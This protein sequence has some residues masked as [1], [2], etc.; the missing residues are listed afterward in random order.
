MSPLSVCRISVLSAV[1]LMSWCI[2]GLHVDV[3]PSK[4]LFRLGQRQQLFCRVQDCP[5]KPSVSW[6]L[7]E[8]Q[9]LAASISSNHT[10]STVTFDPV[11]I[12]HE[13]PILCRVSCG[14]RTIQ[15]LSN[16]RVYS[17]P[18]APQI[19]GQDRLRMGAESFLTC[20]VSHVYPPERLTL[21]WLQG[22]TVRESIMGDPGATTLRSEYR[23]QYGDWGRT[24]SCRATLDLEDLPTE[25]RTQETEVL[26]DPLLAPVVTVF[27]TSVLLMAGAQLN[28]SCTVKGHPE[29]ELSWSFRSADGQ[30][31]ALGSSG[32]LVIDQV[33]L[34][35]DGRY[36][37]EA[38]NSE[39]K[40]IAGVEVRVHAPPTNISLSVS[41][42][43]QVLEGQQVTF[44]CQSD[45]APPPVLVLRREGEELQRTDP[46]SSSVSFSLSS[47]RFQD[48]A[49]YKCEA[50]N[51]YGAQLVTRSLT[52]TAHPMQVELSPPVPAADRGSD[53]LLICRASGCLQPPTF[54]WRRT[55]NNHILFQ[56]KNQNQ[57]QSLLNLQDLDLQDQGGYRCAA[58]CDSV[59]RTADTQVHVYSFP[60]NPVLEVPGPV[61]LGQD[62]ILR[63]NVDGV[64]SANQMRILWLSGNRTLMSK[65]IR[66]LDSLK[67][68]S[69]VLQYQVLEDQPILTC[70]AE[71]L[72]EDGDIWRSRRT[73]VALQMHYPSRGTS[74]SVSPGEQVL[75]GQQVT[76]T[77]Q[78]DGAPPPMLV[79]RR[80]GEELQRT[81]PA[82]SSSLSFSLSSARFQDSASYHCEASNQYGAQLVTRSITVTA[83]PRNTSVL[84]LPSTMVQEGQTITVSCH[85]VCFPPAAIS[86]KN[87]ANGTEL[88]SS[89]GT[90][91]LV[92]VMARDSGMYQVNVTNELGFQVRVFSIRV[93]ERNSSPPSLGSVLIPLL[94]SAV[95]LAAAA[96]LLDYLKR[97]RKKGFY[98]L[99]QTAPPSA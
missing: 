4:P 41:P 64:F 61:L 53:L 39:G 83:P 3:L 1:L 15:T 86:L 8:D 75:E 93:R 47:A 5:T 87:L 67:N 48:S 91:L 34:S 26:L 88:Y 56:S 33:R 52:V 21:I 38:K 59:I 19:G 94:C 40:D 2:Q 6:S 79:L 76:F 22:D 73:S 37:C 62:V 7:L 66:S 51:Q 46:A 27:P 9:P 12:E 23:P 99:P 18:S 20:Q 60:S 49:S 43:E 13:R 68:V 78:S 92:N 70:M 16:V 90:F 89:N 44:T 35:D 80:E 98:Q 32:Q 54:T 36:D 45:G 28:L 85:T 82:S 57:N 72:T 97:S 77:C 17:F 10:G 71:L 11:L 81:D 50:S 74:L 84:V 24:L 55:D 69:S 63:C 65:S 31:V 58:E 95:G 25:D 14:G 29:P 96:L 30:V 42:G